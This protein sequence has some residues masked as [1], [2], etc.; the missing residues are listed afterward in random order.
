MHITT[1]DNERDWSAYR[2]GQ[3]FTYE[4]ARQVADR[5][6]YGYILCY[7]IPIQALGAGYDLVDPKTKEP[8]EKN[9]EIWEIMEPEWKRLAKK[10]VPLSRVF[11]QSYALIIKRNNPD[12]Q[13]EPFTKIFELSQVDE[14]KYYNDETIQL[15]EMHETDY[16]TGL[17]LPYMIE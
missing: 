11:G 2:F 5:D 3:I 15:I 12:H 16:N 6:P 4:N 17:D 8:I 10:G 1:E 7:L 9:D 14:I 13:G